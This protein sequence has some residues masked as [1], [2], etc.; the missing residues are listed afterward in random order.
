MII[1]MIR[2]GGLF[3]SLAQ[4]A[5][6]CD[7]SACIWLDI[8][9]EVEC[10]QKIVDSLLISEPAGEEDQPALGSEAQFGANRLRINLRRLF[11][12]VA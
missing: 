1:K 7:H 12:I 3:E 9:Q 6:A 11:V 8:L 2:V 10:L 4:R 5:I